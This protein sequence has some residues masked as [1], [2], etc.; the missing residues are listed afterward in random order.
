MLLHCSRPGNAGGSLHR[1]VFLMIIS[2]LS[3]KSFS[4][5]FQHSTAGLSP[6]VSVRFLVEL[7]GCLDKLL[8]TFLEMKTA[9]DVSIEHTLARKNPIAR[10]NEYA[11]C[12]AL[13][14]QLQ[15]L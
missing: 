12:V 4:I 14:P 11:V 6:D 13:W 15:I 5:C 7:V 1:L 10:R 3:A 9:N 8:F 2:L